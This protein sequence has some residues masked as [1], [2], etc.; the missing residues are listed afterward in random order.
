MLVSVVIP[1]YNKE[2]YISET[3]R[4]VLDQTYDNFQ[5]IIVD[6]GSTDKS[7]DEVEKFDDERIRI[8]SQENAGV[9]AARNRGI[10]EAKFEFIAFLDADD[11]WEKDFL[12]TMMALKE[13][14]DQCSVFAVNYKV[15]SHDK[16]THAPII[17]GLAEGFEEGVLKNYFHLAS[18]SDPIIWSSSLMVKKQAIESIGGFPSEIRAGEDLLTWARLAARYDIAYTLE[19]KATFCKWDDGKN[20]FPRIPDNHD[21][22]GEELRKLLTEGDKDKIDGLE[23]YIA[24]WHKIRVAIFLRLDKKEE[25]RKEF[26][27]MSEFAEKNI[28]YFI[29]ALLVYSPELLNKRLLKISNYFNTLIR[30]FKKKQGRL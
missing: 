7:V 6:D 12:E 22:V 9:S 29:Y 19:Q 24:Y 2:K 17:N 16:S 14:Y 23:K 11:L 3:I 13:K 10:K 20:A 21:R 25:A 4:S 8:I 1:L 5:I 27:K 26:K 15:M 18:Q 28:K 30:N